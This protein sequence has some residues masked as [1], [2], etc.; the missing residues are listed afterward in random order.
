MPLRDHFHSPV[1]DHHSWDGFHG[2][3]PAMVVM[4]LDQHLPRNYL[5]VP[6][7]HLGS[8]EV[9][10]GTLDNDEFGRW[11]N[12]NPHGSED[13]ATAVYAPPTPALSVA[14]E[15]PDLSEYEVR[16]YDTDRD[17]R[18][19]AAIEFVSPGNKDRP[20]HRTAFVTKC[21]SLLQSRVAVS[22]VDLV[23]TREANLYLD[24]LDS[25][26]QS[27]TSLGPEPVSLYAA[28]CRWIKQGGTWLFQT[29][30]NAL[31]LG[32][33]LPTLPLWLDDQLAIPLELEASYEATCRILRIS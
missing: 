27:D 7:V 24:L 2:A 23:T 13:A 8:L 1:N 18:L 11:S 6:T 15:S 33:P 3:W 25:L 32:Q 19:V 17:R 9:D 5:A 14:T 22:L 29:W 20:E 16:I 21:R 30:P 26:G 4:Q 28:S 10:V 12:G 31:R